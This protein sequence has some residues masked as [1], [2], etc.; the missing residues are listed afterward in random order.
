MTVPFVGL[1][2]L[3]LALLVRGLIT[4]SRRRA[5][6][7]ARSTAGTA[8]VVA[9]RA[10]RNPD[11]ERFDTFVVSVQYAD[12]NGQPRSADLPASQEFQPGDPIDIRFDP[13]NPAAVHLGEQFAGISLPMA[14]IVFGGL[15]MLV[16]FV[17][18]R[19]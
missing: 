13:N 14:L 7:I 2:C 19:D 3:G 8:N 10:V 1:F 18:V 9:C 4:A 6:W 17:Y 16:S 11:T 15:L 12:A 5:A